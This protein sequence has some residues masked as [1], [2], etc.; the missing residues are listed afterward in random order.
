MGASTRVGLTFYKRSCAILVTGG[1]CFSSPGLSSPVALASQA[2]PSAGQPRN[3]RPAPAPEAPTTSE[4][5]PS[6][7]AEQGRAQAQ[8][9]PGQAQANMEGLSV[10]PELSKK[11]LNRVQVLGWTSLLSGLALGAGASA[12]LNGAQTAEGSAQRILRRFDQDA[13]AH[14]IYREVQADYDGHLKKAGAMRSTALA[15]TVTA[16][17]AFLTG[18]T[19]AIM[20]AIKKK[21]PKQ[22]RISGLRLRF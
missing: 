1:L 13:G 4:E 15:L 9:G 14:P 7:A 22:A 10:D 21:E 19:L 5:A 3:A 17:V 6:T 8:E 16:G 2:Q 18:V 20:G 11:P 12:L